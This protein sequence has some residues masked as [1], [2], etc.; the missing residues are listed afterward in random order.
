MN[1]I[2]SRLLCLAL[3]LAT[4]FAHA[5]NRPE[6]AKYGAAYLG[7]EQLQVYVA[8]S[9]ADDRAV[10]KIRG[11]N[12]PLDGH[13]FWTKI[14]Y[15]KSHHSKGYS[16]RITYNDDSVKEEGKGAVLF[17][18][19]SSGILYLPNYRG[20]ARAEIPLNHDK[21]ASGEVLPEHLLTDYERQIGVT[22]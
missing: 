10:I 22:K 20:Q 2:F 11:I 7:P 1:S 8:H 15:S 16:D 14:S 9:K 17:V 6:M 4:P 12:H 5:W 21:E 3:L 19:D 13:V 18:E